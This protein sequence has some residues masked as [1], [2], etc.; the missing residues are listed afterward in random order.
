MDAI[1]NFFTAFGLS[2]SAGLNAYIPLLITGLMARYTD[3][4]TLQQPFDTLENPFVLLTLGVLLL[5]EMFVDK[6]PALDTVNDVIHTLIR[7]AAGAVLFTAN[8]GVVGSMDPT[9]A[10][11]LGLV[12]AGSIHATKTV[13]RPLITASTAGFGNPIVSFI[14]DVVAFIASLLAIMMPFLMAFF[15]IFVFFFIIRWWWRRRRRAARV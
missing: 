2:S 9:L 4:L 3:L 15:T 12:A 14:E 6:I 10:A 8:A 1:L 13:A 11:I 7:P 5:V